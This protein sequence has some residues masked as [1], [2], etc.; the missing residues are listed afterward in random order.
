MSITQLRLEMSPANG[1]HAK[2]GSTLIGASYHWVESVNSFGL[3]SSHVADCKLFDYRFMMTSAAI[4]A[5]FKPP[6]LPQQSGD[7]DAAWI[8]HKH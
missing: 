8:L 3:C 1:V 5:C 4:L 2:E 6:T 7:S